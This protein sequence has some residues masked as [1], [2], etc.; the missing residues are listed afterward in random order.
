MFIKEIYIKTFLLRFT[1]NPTSTQ[2][3]KYGDKII[4]KSLNR[5]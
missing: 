2:S 4:C 1:A 5:G 3:S